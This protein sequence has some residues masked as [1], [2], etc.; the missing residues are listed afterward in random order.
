MLDHFIPATV[1]SPTRIPWLHVLLF[2][3][4]SLGDNFTPI[5][6]YAPTGTGAPAAR[7]YEDPVEL[8]MKLLNKVDPFVDMVSPLCL[9]KLSSAFII[10]SFVTI[11]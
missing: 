4:C 11:N 3:N 6:A 7:V 10:I 1:R 8:S 5:A 9:R 2:P